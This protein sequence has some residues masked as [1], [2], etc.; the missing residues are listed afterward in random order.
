MTSSSLFVAAA[1]AGLAGSPHCVA[2]C[3]AACAG[4][5]GKR[6][7]HAL[8]CQAGR[9]IGYAALGA[10]AAASAWALGHGLWD[11]VAAWC[12]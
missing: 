5:T 1:V 3:G 12:A 10:L 6:A 8:A 11:T 9:L 4:V 7:G 2:M